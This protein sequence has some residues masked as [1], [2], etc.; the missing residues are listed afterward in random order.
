MARFSRAIHVEQ[1]PEHFKQSLN[2]MGHK[3]KATL[4]HSFEIEFITLPD[5]SG[6]SRAMT[7]KKTYFPSPTARVIRHCATGAKLRRWWG[8]TPRRVRPARWAA[9]P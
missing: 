7:R 1:F 3:K 4:L 8:V 5:S 9:V 2:G 6:S